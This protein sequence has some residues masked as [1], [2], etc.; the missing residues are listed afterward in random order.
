VHLDSG[1]QVIHNSLVAPLEDRGFPRKFDS[2]PVVCKS[3][4]KETSVI[5]GPLK[6][7]NQA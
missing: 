3:G 1:L 2:T 5:A 7:A 6:D 4:G